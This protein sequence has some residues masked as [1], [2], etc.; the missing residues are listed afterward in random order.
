MEGPV[1]KVQISTETSQHGLPAQRPPQT[2]PFRVFCVSV[3][4]L[5]IVLSIVVLH[6]LRLLSK[7]LVLLQLLHQSFFSA[8][9]FQWQPLSVSI[10]LLIS[11]SESCSSKKFEE[12]S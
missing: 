6:R 1:A 11:L 9:F 2:S 10:L 12:P 5:Q 4:L 3:Q 8:Q 7:P